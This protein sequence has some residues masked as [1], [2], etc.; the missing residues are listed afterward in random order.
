[1]GH[2]LD[3]VDNDDRPTL[4][5]QLWACI[6]SSSDLTDD[7][8]TARHRAVIAGYAAAAVV[9]ITVL[10]IGELR[11]P[12]GSFS[13][14]ATDGMLTVLPAAGLAV[15]RS[16]L[17]RQLAGCTGILVTCGVL[18]HATG[19]LIEAHFSF[20]VV[21]PLIALYTDWR[22][23]AFSVAYIAIGHGVLGAVSPEGMYNHQAAVDRPFLWGFIHA[24]FVLALCLAMLLHWNFSDRKRL[25]LRQTLDQLHQTQSQL[26]E[27]QK[28]ESI[29]SLAAGVAHEINT[30]I[31]FVGDNL[32]FINQTASDLG[33]FIDAYRREQDNMVD[34][35]SL[36]RLSELADELDLGF[37]L[38]EM[39][40]AVT[41]SLEGVQ[42]VAEIVRAM[43]GFSHPKN[44]IVPT[45]LNALI[46]DA[47]VV[48]RSEWKYAAEM[49]L[50]LADGLPAVPVPPGSFNQVLLNLIVNAAHAIEDARDEGELGTIT[51]R[52]R[53]LDDE[54]VAVSVGD[55]GCGIPEH[56]RERVL[57]QFFTTKEVG[58][59]TG[60]GLS[61][62]HG[63]IQS[64]GGRIEI[65]SEVDV[66]TTVTAVLPIREPSAAPAADAGVVAAAATSTAVG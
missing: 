2:T 18:V 3:D 49:D 47:G 19:G 42:R 25:E 61:I 62:A 55:D 39:P 20:F 29:G 54:M 37:L 51:I 43:K 38:D 14:L 59:G 9:T 1:M 22:P 33:R 66:G 40:R 31:Q 41:Q 64:L 57:E 16:R 7:E 17:A 58:R 6:P 65:E 26:V 4:A 44:D 24:A 27:A 11:A 56:L 45:D 63:L 13:H 53:L 46:T 30:P 35:E 10:I 36:E 60:Q 5:A 50:D 8:F 48:S 28:L 52:S 32:T 15:F 21:L 12:D 34:G 23:F